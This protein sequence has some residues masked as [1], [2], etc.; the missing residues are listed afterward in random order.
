MSMIKRGHSENSKPT[1]ISFTR[2]CTKCGHTGSTSL[3]PKCQGKM[4]ETNKCQN[5]T[6]TLDK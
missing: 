3:C 1:V 6:C 2:K 5:G 4:V